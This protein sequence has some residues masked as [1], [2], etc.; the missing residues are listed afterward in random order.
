MVRTQF[1]KFCPIFPSLGARE[2][3][4]SEMSTAIGKTN[5]QI[6]SGSPQ[7]KD[8]GK[9]GR[10]LRQKCL[11]ESKGCLFEANTTEVSVAP[12]PP[13]QQKVRGEPRLPWLQGCNMTAK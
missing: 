9:K 8:Q 5:K 7:P 12:S 11:I 10:V 6:K 4:N 13:Q 2:V 3:S 1:L